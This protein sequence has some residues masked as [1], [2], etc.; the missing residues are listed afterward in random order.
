MNISNI[1]W[2]LVLILIGVIFGL[3]ALEITSIN[4]F[5]DGWWTLF[6]ILPCGIS[7]LSSDKNK[8]SNLIG[9]I[10][11]IALLLSSWSILKFELIWKLML[12]TILVLIGISLI[13]I[14]RLNK[15]V[16]EK[17]IKLNESNKDVKEYYATFAGQKLNFSSEEFTG[18]SLNATCGSIE[19][20]LRDTK[21]KENVVIFCS[22]IFGGITIL[23]PE[24]VDVKIT[25]T[26]I[27]GGV[28]NKKKNSNNN[29]YTIYID[30]TCMFGG[31]DIK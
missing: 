28:S 20:D 23:V 15:K 10:I 19:C 31:V 11:G 21:I 12:P 14:N 25:S 29:K 2:G 17:I 22:S 16:K 7:L 4:I 5:F 1:L 9:L 3:N 8:T 26:P 6:L 30:A 18:C 24:D 13:F 27:F